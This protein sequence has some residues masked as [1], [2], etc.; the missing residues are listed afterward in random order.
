[1]PPGVHDAPFDPKFSGAMEL[2]SAMEWLKLDKESKALYA[3][4][5][6]SDTFQ[7]SGSAYREAVIDLWKRYEKAGRAI[8]YSQLTAL[9]QPGIGHPRGS[10]LWTHE[11]SLGKMY[12]DLGE[13]ATAAEWYAKVPPEGLGPL[14]AADELF[15]AGRHDDAAAK[16]SDILTH[17]DDWAAKQP[18]LR[19]T[20]LAEPLESANL[21][22]VKK[23][24][25]ERLVQIKK[26]K[27]ER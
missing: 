24:I 19:D 3:D 21:A 27:G 26:L 16:Y 20:A 2:A 15:A 10:T 13:H 22:N 17:L 11:L 9:N 4:F 5:F 1:M 25:E 7:K 6:A 8:P 14:K 18:R 23:H 12:A